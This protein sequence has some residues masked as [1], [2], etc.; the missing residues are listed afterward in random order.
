MDEDGCL[1][2]SCQEDKMSSGNSS[3]SESQ[4]GGL[5]RLAMQLAKVIQILLTMLIRNIFS[6]TSWHPIPTWHL[7]KT[8]LVHTATQT[9]LTLFASSVQ[10]RSVVVDKG[11]EAKNVCKEH[12]MEADYWLVTL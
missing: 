3:P 7:F 12:N 1:S 6:T 9:V 2:D 10:M 11:E 5:K 4:G 8:D